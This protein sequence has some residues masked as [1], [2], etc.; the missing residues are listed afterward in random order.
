MN[1][2]TPLPCWDKEVMLTPGRSCICGADPM[3]VRRKPI[4]L[5]G[6]RPWVLLGFILGA[7]LPHCP[8]LEPLWLLSACG[9]T[10]FLNLPSLSVQLQ[11]AL[12]FQRA[13]HHLWNCCS[14]PG[15]PVPNTS[16][17]KLIKRVQGCHTE[18]T[19]EARQEK[20]MAK[21]AGGIYHPGECLNCGS[22][23]PWAV[24]DYNLTEI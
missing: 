19:T 15:S 13:S 23:D 14:V 8:D 2:Q 21:G 11:T 17:S 7:C 18:I 3:P 10:S 16:D 1:L 22:S 5:P 9:R 4:L 12:S 6:H 20:V 24:A